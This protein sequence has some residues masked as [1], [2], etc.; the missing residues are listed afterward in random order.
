M[1]VDRFQT[2]RDEV[3]GNAAAAAAPDGERRASF[4]GKWDGRDRHRH[5]KGR[6]RESGCCGT[7]ASIVVVCDAKEAAER[8]RWEGQREEEEVGE[9]DREL[10][11]RRRHLAWGA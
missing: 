2:L 3:L 11:S 5:W 4:G 10:T 6:T 9:F 8:R 1:T 7:T